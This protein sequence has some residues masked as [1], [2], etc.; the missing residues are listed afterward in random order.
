M[1]EVP[2]IHICP[3]FLA[4]PELDSVRLVLDGVGGQGA[5]RAETERRAIESGHQGIIGTAVR[6]SVNQVD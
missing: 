3:C 2:H 1:G 6:D 5:D 4:S